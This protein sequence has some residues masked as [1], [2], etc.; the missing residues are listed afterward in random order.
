MPLNIID[1]PKSP[2]WNS[3]SLWSETFWDYRGNP[4]DP[5]IWLCSAG[6]SEP[7]CIDL[8]GNVG[9][10]WKLVLL[11]GTQHAGYAYNSHT[12]YLSLDL[13]RAHSR[14]RAVGGIN[15]VLWCSAAVNLLV[16]LLYSRSASFLQ[17]Y[18]KMVSEV[19]LHLYWC[20][21]YLEISLLPKLFR[22]QHSWVYKVQTPTL[23]S[24]I[25]LDLRHP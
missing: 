13:S 1:R 6:E 3:A 8:F 18:G 25:E 9:A 16:L 7:A 10:G 12:F 11:L 2:L 17:N 4:R 22:R 24:R 21:D 5:S 15:R 20:L 14:V 19:C 23:D